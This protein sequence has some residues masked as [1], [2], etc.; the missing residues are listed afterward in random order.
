M[1]EHGVAWAS[2][3]LLLALAATAL[4]G[5]YK[6]RFTP[7]ADYVL[8]GRLARDLPPLP[9]VPFEYVRKG[10]AADRLSE[11]PAAGVHPRVALS[12][13]DIAA[14]R[15]KVALGEKADRVFRVMVRELRNKAALPR[16]ARA[17]YGGAPWAGIGVI[18]AKALLALIAEDPKLGREAAEWTMKHAQ[19]L[20]PRID[21]LNTH[22]GAKGWRENFY[23]F[24]RTGL[25]VGGVDYR[26]AF[27]QG[28]AAG[29][30]TLA[31][32]SV[33][34]FGEDNQWAYTS[35]GAEYDYAHSFMTD[36]Q[37]AYVRKVI[38]KST[39]GKYSTGMEIPGHFFINNHMSMGAEFLPLALAIEGEEG[40]DPRILEV[41]A[42][43]L[44]DKLTYDI[45]PDGTLYENVKGFIPRIPIL[46]AARRGDRTLLRHSHLLARVHAEARNAEHLY[47]RY[48]HRGRNRP[49]EALPKP[50]DNVEEP[51]FWC[52]PSGRSLQFVWLVK[53]FYPDDP[54][55][56]F[57]YKIRT[58]QANFDVFDGSEDETN[59]GGRIHY[60]DRN[61][62]D[63][64][65]L[66]ATD[67]LRD[68]DGKVVDYQQ[69]LTP[70]ITGLP[71]VWSDLRR[72]IAAA[73]SSWNPDALVAHYECRSDFFY[74][75]HETPEHGDFT[76]SAHG[77]QWSPYTG[78]YMD[79]YFR[80]MVL[81]DGLAGV[82][83]PVAGRMVGVHDSPAA[84]TFV[85]DA[86]DGYR[87]RKLEKLFELDH[88]M[89]DEAP[90]FTA[91]E[92]E[93]PFRLD[94]FTELPFHPHMREFYDGF[95][96]L[97]YG[98]WHGETRG[99]ERY[100][101]WNDVRRVYRTFHLARG[102]RPYVLIVDDVQKDGQPHQYD[103][104]LNVTGD[105]V[106][107]AANSKAKNRHLTPDTHGAIGTDLILCLGNSPRRQTQSSG[108]RSHSVSLKPQPR[109]GDP[110]LL[111]R[112]LWRNTT[113]P[114]PL[115]TFEQGWR[116]N[117]VKVPAMAVTPDF[118]VL[119]FPYRFGEK[120]PMTAWSDDH[121]QL[122]VAFDGQRD[123]Y[124]FGKTD[125]DRT[126][127]AMERDG[128][129]A[130][131]TEARPPRPVLRDAA[132][133]FTDALEVSFEPPA[134]GTEIRTTL[135]GREPSPTS[136]L[137]TGPVALTRSATLKAKTFHRNWRFGKEP[138]SETLSVAFRKVKPAKPANADAS[139]LSPGLLVSVYEIKT[140]LYDE[141]GFFVGTK[142]SLPKLDDYSP[143]LQTI[144]DAFGVPDA[145][146][147][148]PARLMKKA[149]YR[150]VGYF[151]AEREGVYRFRVDSCGPVVLR[152]GDATPIEVTGQYGLSKKP[153][154]GEVALAKGLHA[155]ELVVTDPVFWKG[156][157]ETPYTIEVA[158]RAPGS[159]A[160]Q[161]VGGEVLRREPSD[162][163]PIAKPELRAPRPKR[164]SGLVA[165]L[166]QRRYDW[167]AEAPADA[168]IPANGLPAGF[169]EGIDRAT[170]YAQRAVS[171]LAGNDYLKRLIEYRGTLRVVVP[172]LY[173]FRLDPLGANQLVIGRVEVTHNRLHAP[174]APG[175]IRLEPGLHPLSL[176][177]ARGKATLDVLEPLAK[178]FAPVAM[179]DLLRPAKVATLGDPE[180]LVAHLAFG[181]LEGEQTPVAG[182][183]QA[184]AR[185]E[186]ATLADG[187]RSGKAVEMKEKT[188]KVVIENLT[189]LDDA[190][191][192]AVWLKR[193][194]LTDGFLVD[195]PG[196]LGVRLRGKAIWASYYR[197]PDLAQCNGGKA[198]EPGTWFHLAVTWGDEVRVYL[199]GELKA[200][201]QVDRSAFHT[202]STDA[203]AERIILFNETWERGPVPGIADD[204]RIYNRVLSAEDIKRLCVP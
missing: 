24:S 20:E 122:T 73:R 54:V 172:G 174:R 188:A 127:L 125:D 138:G 56:D 47:N 190:C 48:I 164:V 77:V 34:F 2:S 149:F 109:Q 85:S 119:L 160:W 33:E 28:G 185:I 99:P 126:V 84:A 40:Y 8:S 140:T 17:E 19:F 97:D 63:L 51:R 196:K 89:L 83:Q 184:T 12:P 135:N 157:M 70:A 18:G 139:K 195:A 57:L 102:T 25:R 124:T 68:G 5:E 136:T 132:R 1:T 92:K 192:I 22:P 69:G 78:P 82:Y 38:S 87:W 93:N 121:T 26:R 49:R 32:K 59:Y 110:M 150:Y 142:R 71:R 147:Q 143:I 10:Y 30:A 201:A 155:L 72:G 193:S 182:Q 80:N 46:A 16:P 123:V 178:D 53:H 39:R 153:R 90:C 91:W 144:T 202:P 129:P 60:N 111:V 9:K 4:C 131:R 128:T 81:I 101:K 86:T 134:P 183:P 27:E 199:N 145:E 198:V 6:G 120:L 65:L 43:R 177:I 117:R 44:A 113:F 173:G 148:A 162:A 79:C 187:G 67:G 175:R 194:R 191:T 137:Y 23:Y 104:C 116:W 76:L 62:L 130:A 98:P 29:V 158:A 151:L 45:S 36:T 171:V 167:T 100:Q 112:V 176:R 95:G 200:S 141:R 165:G 11:V 88:P 41:Y 108:L 42:P 203:R 96:H 74:A 154:V 35:L 7:D 186:D 197:S 179:A 75:G 156:A 94:R 105:A 168:K 61:E 3:A 114:Y 118:R 115:P 169:F 181:K 180:R 163:K 106:L 13:S 161:V 133:T 189:M 58:A 64:Q 50:E 204:V 14:I 152:L 15:R 159:D 170:P 31:K 66:A 107:Y 103:W 146:P 166:V 52:A 21:I 55:V 37:R